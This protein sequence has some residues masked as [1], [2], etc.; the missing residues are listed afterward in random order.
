MGIFRNA[1]G[2]VSLGFVVGCSD[3]AIQDSVIYQA[4]IGEY[5]QA[6]DQQELPAL[7]EASTISYWS[8]PSNPTYKTTDVLFSKTFSYVVAVDNTATG[9]VF[10]L[11]SNAM[12][13]EG[14]VAISGGIIRATRF[15]TNSNYSYIE[16]AL[17]A[18]ASKILIA[19]N[20]AEKSGANDISLMVNGMLFQDR[21]VVGTP[22]DFSYLQKFITSTPAGG[23]VLEYLVYSDF[24]S[25]S[26][27]NVMSRYI[28]RENSIPNVVYDPALMS[29]DGGTT[30][31]VDNPQFLAAKAIIDAQCISCHKPSSSEGDLSNLTQSKALANGWVVAGSPT[32]S[33][34]YYRLSGSL[35][36]GTKDMPRNS[37]I[38][39]SDVQI[40]YDWISGIK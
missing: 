40:V 37:S 18:G 15:S 13:E 30:T 31:P 7:A 5:Q 11:N 28:A 19:V 6:L 9:T 4:S 20:F 25:N 21:K 3:L 34:L 24:L 39:A 22:L 29:G 33:K 32:T 35:G 14:R 2:L 8:K 1:A 12:N 36:P 23:T 16:A 10:S 17:P 26:K 27:L 38:S